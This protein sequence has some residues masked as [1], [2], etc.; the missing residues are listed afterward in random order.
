MVVGQGALGRLVQGLF[1]EAVFQ[2]GLDRTHRARPQGEGALGGGFEPGIGVGLG[3]AQDPEAGAVALFGMTPS[4]EDVSDERAR[5]GSD[6][7]GPSREA[8]GRPLLGEQAVFLGHVLGHGGMSPGGMGAHVAG[9]ALPVV[10]EF[11]GVGGVSGVEL[12]PDEG[13]GDGVVVAF[14]LD[15]VVDGTRTFFHWAKT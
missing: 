7:L 11:D 10:E 1:V 9:D 14:E 6:L 13:V 12:A 2:D 8:L 4:L 3:Q 5:G 15:V